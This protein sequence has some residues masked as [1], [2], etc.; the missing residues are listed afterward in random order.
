MY[1]YVSQQVLILRVIFTRE[2]DTL[3]KYNQIGKKRVQKHLISL[4]WEPLKCINL[5]AFKIENEPK[6]SKNEIETNK[7]E[8]VAKLKLC[9]L[10]ES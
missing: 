6:R 1:L 7:Y 5:E 2:N 10:K 4:G 8:K 3:K 9:S